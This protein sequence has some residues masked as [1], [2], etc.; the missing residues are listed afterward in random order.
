MKLKFTVFFFQ[1]IFITNCFSQQLRGSMF[2]A[3][4]CKDGILIGED[5]RVALAKPG[6]EVPKTRDDIYCYSDT[7]QKIFIVRNFAF[8][9]AG[10]QTFGSGGKA[11]SYYLKEFENT[12]ND[13]STIYAGTKFFQFLYKNYPELSKAFFKSQILMAGYSNGKAYLHDIYNG[14]YSISTDAVESNINFDGLKKLYDAT[15]TCAQA[16]PIIEK[17]IK[18][19]AKKHHKE[20]YIGGPIMILK[21]SSDNTF[22]WLRNRPKSKPPGNI[23]EIYRRMLSKR[24]KTVYTSDSAKL[25]VTRVIKDWLSTH[26]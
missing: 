24:L 22:T 25:Y 5:T 10:A 21:I 20:F 7:I 15:L 2:I 12:L 6:I 16:A 3:D 8:C 23:F 17:L 1:L 14:K 26:Q 11:I 19:Y 4:I 9:S 13:T 18:N